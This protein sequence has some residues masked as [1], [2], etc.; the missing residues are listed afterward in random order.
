MGND[1]HASDILKLNDQYRLNIQANATVPMLYIYAQTPTATD[2]ALANG[3]VD[4][5][6]G[7][8]AD[9][10]RS[11]ETP[12][13]KQIHLLQLGRARGEVIN[14]GIDWQAAVL[15]FL[16]TFGTSARRSSWWP[17]SGTD[18]ER[19]QLANGPRAADDRWSCSPSCA[20]C[21]DI[22]SRSLWEVVIAAVL[23]FMSVQGASRTSSVATQQL[24]L[25]T[26]KSQLL[27]RTR[28]RRHA[29]LASG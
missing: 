20:G 19:R 29:G 6:R 13:T 28:R 5:M 9:L 18:G 26:P 16:L 14:A 15:A 27:N 24:M 23:A 22:R 4:A 2:E 21:G 7:Y 11:T 17:G 1:R 8:L 12:D 10:A 25:D 3:A